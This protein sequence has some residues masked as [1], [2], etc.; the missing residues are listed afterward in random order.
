MGDDAT[1]LRPRT[2]GTSE[3]P[4]MGAHDVRDQAAGLADQAT[5]QASSLAGQVK[6]KAPDL[7][8]FLSARLTPFRIAGT[9]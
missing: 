7:L 6:D 4:E 1:G 3:Q 2:P 8:P 5:Q 9:P